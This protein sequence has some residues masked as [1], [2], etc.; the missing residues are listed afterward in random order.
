[1]SW[2]DILKNMQP[3]EEGIWYSPQGWTNTNSGFLSKVWDYAKLAGLL[4]KPESNETGWFDVGIKYGGKTI[5]FKNEY[6]DDNHRQQ[7][8]GMAGKFGVTGELDK[9]HAT[10][11]RG[12]DMVLEQMNL[13]RNSEYALSMFDKNAAQNYLNKLNQSPKPQ[14]K[15]GILSRFSG[16]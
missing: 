9:E 2:K 12:I 4:E 3:E 10:I 11:I 6:Q 14:P 5:L 1:M 13:Q 8:R 7:A 15:K 16:K